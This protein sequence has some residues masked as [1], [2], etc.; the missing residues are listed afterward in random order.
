LDDDSDRIAR[1]LLAMGIGPGTRLAL[2]VP[3]GIDFISL[4]FGLFKA[5]AE[6]IL[7][8]PGMGRRSLIG[9]LAEAEPEGFV[10]VPLA[11]AVRCLL[12]RRFLQECVG[13]PP[14]RKERR[15]NLE[16]QTVTTRRSDKSIQ[17]CD[18]ENTRNAE[19][20]SPIRLRDEAAHNN[21]PDGP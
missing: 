13:V 19:S 11:Q 8:D 3:A 21:S 18:S 12:R 4:V 1:G 6:A 5:G 16:N 17:K 7:I 15:D 20:R 10:A 14:Q 9:C 2:L